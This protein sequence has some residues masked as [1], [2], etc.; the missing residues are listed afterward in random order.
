MRG[1][2][3]RTVLVGKL[4]WERRIYFSGSKPQSGYSLL[5]S[6]PSVPGDDTQTGAVEVQE[7]LSEPLPLSMMKQ[8]VEDPLYRL[9]TRRAPAQRHFW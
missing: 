9:F 7:R 6:L 8:R 5:P 4:E 1:L 2:R 3:Y